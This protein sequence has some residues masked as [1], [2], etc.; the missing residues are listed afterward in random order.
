VEQRGLLFR[1][2]R[3]RHCAIRNFLCRLE[4]QASRMAAGV[5]N[6]I[7]LFVRIGRRL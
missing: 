7:A 5:A 3:A 2:Q 1:A 6:H 4:Q